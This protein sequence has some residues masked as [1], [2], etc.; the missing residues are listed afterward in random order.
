MC[1]GR[2]K[3]LI[4]AD[5]ESHKAIPLAA[6]ERGHFGRMEAEIRLTVI[7]FIWGCRRPVSLF[8]GAIS[9]QRRKAK[10][11]AKLEKSLLKAWEEF[12]K[13]DL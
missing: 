10:Q 2:R 4:Y 13:S 1:A 8:F 5:R 9:V 3:H 12:K 11:E 7:D 6:G